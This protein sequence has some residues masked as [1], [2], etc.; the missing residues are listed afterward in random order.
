MLDNSSNKTEQQILEAAYRV[1]QKKGR[2]GARM[3]EIADEAGINK[4][5]LHY[6]FRNK[7][8][9]FRKIFMQ[10]IA[11]FLGSVI[12]MLNNVETTWQEKISDFIAHY[13]TFLTKRPDL[14]LFVMNEINQHPDEFFNQLQ[15]ENIL[16]HTVFFNQLSAAA[17]R[18]EIR[19]IHPI[20]V[21][22]T[23]LSNIVFP[24]IA[25]PIIKKV[26]AF[27]DSNWEHF[28]EDRVRITKEIIINYLEKV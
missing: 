28:M 23:M 4:S 25:A 24:F 6:Y 7:D 20:Q 16:M 10:S 2:A 18:G 13:N 3:Q 14:P 27:T 22:V 12:P 21:F 9:L 5:M 17:E 1:F 15:I 19:T 11:E 26:A 8:S